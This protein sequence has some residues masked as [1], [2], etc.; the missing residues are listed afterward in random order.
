MSAAEASDTFAVPIAQAE[1]RWYDTTSWAGWVDGL[2]RVLE[3][4][5]PW[6]RAGGQVVW[7]SGPAGRGRVSERC[8][9]YE[10]RRGQSAEVGDDSITG[11]QTV[12]FLAAGD[13]VRVTLRLEYRLRRRSPLTPL[14]DLLFI[15]R[16]MRGSLERTLG[17]F[18][19]GLGA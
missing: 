11:V 16:E 8:I 17:R 18:G 12:A 9:A 10:P 7:E 6:P 5:A 4:S 2:E 15:R 1:E 13:G 3:V 14:I 19:A